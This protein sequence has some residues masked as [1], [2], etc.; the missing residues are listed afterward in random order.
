MTTETMPMTVRFAQPWIDDNRAFLS[1]MEEGRN[2][3][4]EHLKE[5]IRPKLLEAGFIKTA[6]DDKPSIMAAV[7]AAVCDVQ[8][9]DIAL[10][11]VQAAIYSDGVTTF[12]A[13]FRFGPFSAEAVR[14]IRTPARMAREVALLAKAQTMTIADNSLWSFLMEFNQAI[15]AR[16]NLASEEPQFA[17]LVDTLTN[18]DFV[19]ML[20]NE[21][22]VAMP[23]LGVSQALAKNKL[24][25]EYFYGPVTDR[26]ACSLILDEGEYL[27]PQPLSS[28]GSFGIEKRGSEEGD[29]ETIRYIY[30]KELYFTYYRP[31]RYKQAYRVEARKALLNNKLFSSIKEAT[32]FREIAEPEPQFMVDFNVKQLSGIAKLYGDANRSRMPFFG[33]H[34]TAR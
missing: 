5:N 30:E 19:R 3:T 6:G 33:Y 16:H 7:D 1:Q 21:N 26:A 8:L 2:R 22:L 12:D 25:S 14:F 24:F 23:K 15:T 32:K 20:E 11:L 29:R 31:W 9:D 17:N 27:Y 34:R 10:V 18:G 13:P 28:I 4:I